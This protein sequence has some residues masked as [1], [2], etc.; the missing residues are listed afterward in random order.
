MR[1]VYRPT[2]QIQAPLRSFDGSTLLTDRI[3]VPHPW[4]EHYSSLFRDRRSIQETPIRK[5]P[6]QNVELEVNNPP[7]EAEITAAVAKLQPGEA[8]GIGGLLAE[9]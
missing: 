8:P 5:I 6:Q 9:E 4:T 3:S 7:T 2:H 1:G